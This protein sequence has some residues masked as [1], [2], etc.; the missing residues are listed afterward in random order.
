MVVGTKY[1][2][3]LSP[4]EQQWMKNAAQFSSK[5]QQEF[6][7]KNVEECMQT[8]EAANVK[9]YKP[10]KALFAEKTKAVLNEFVKDPNM[11]KIVDKI[12]A[13]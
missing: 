8:L 9:I 3:T 12:K 6:W 13:E 7:K 4:E 2:E 11:K 1:W 10:E 5:A